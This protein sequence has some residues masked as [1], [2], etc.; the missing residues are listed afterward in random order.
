MEP[1]GEF[2]PILSLALSPGYAG[3]RIILAGAESH[4]LLRSEDRR[5][6]WA[7]LGEGTI[8]ESVNAILSAPDYPMTPD[9]VVMLDTALLRSHN[10]GRSWVAWHVDEAGDGDMTAVAAPGGLRPDAVVLIGLAGGGV[11]RL[12]LKGL[13]QQ[14]ARHE[15]STGSVARR[16]RQPPTCQPTPGSTARR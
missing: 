13:R 15:T 2:A 7:R 14:R 11:R 8:T 5:R 1:A 12:H 6:T 4:G 3:E 16:R 10:R 9:L